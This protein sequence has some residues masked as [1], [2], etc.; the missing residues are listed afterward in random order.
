MGLGSKWVGDTCPEDM[1]KV[2][3]R[4]GGACFL[5][6]LLKDIFGGWQLQREVVL[7]A[8]RGFLR[9]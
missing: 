1:Q 9:K 8:V 4:F 3:D 6:G 2:A 7:A 5:L